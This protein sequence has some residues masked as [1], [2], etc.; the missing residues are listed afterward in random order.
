MKIERKKENKISRIE[1]LSFPYLLRYG[2]G[3]EL[4]M[5]LKFLFNFHEM[6]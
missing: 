5:K 2:L 6:F 3:L 4:I 1:N